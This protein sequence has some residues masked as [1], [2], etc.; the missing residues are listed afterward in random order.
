VPA[1]A[2]LSSWQEMLVSVRLLLPMT[3]FRLLTLPL[4]LADKKAKK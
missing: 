3:L 4:F 2:V 1:S